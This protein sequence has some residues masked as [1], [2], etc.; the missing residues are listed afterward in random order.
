[1]D[2]IGIGRLAKLTVVK[3][4]QFVS[5][6][7]LDF[8]LSR[9]APRAISV[10]TMRKPCTGSNSSITP[11]TWDL[12]LMKFARCLAWQTCRMRPAK[13]SMR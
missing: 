2:G 1:M 12:T 6:S 13:P 9:C 10:V 11:V 3:V 4:P 5:T 8:Y 7:R